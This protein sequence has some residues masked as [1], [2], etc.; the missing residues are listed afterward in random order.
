MKTV[1]KLTFQY[2]HKNVKNIFLSQ[3]IHGKNC[4]TCKFNNADK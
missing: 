1:L 3:F 2:Q 4:F